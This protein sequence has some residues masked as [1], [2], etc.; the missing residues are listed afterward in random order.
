MSEFK[1]ITCQKTDAPKWYGM[2]SGVLKCR[3]CYLREKQR[4]A[5]KK[6]SKGRVYDLWGEG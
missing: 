3:A 4:A 1:C 6:K 5:R 2:R